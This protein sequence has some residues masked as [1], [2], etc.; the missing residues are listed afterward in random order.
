M[1]YLLWFLRNE[2][3]IFGTIASSYYSNAQLRIRSFTFVNA[4]IIWDL[5]HDLLEINFKKDNVS[6]PFERN[7]LFLNLA[8]EIVYFSDLINKSKFNFINNDLGLIPLDKSYKL[9]EWLLSKI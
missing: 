8:K 2:R 9:T 1:I 3:D 6:E 7:D 4:F 5:N